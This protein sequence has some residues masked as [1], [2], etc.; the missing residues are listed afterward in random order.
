MRVSDE[1]LEARPIWL[2]WFVMRQDEMT[3][4]DLI[5]TWRIGM[6]GVLSFGVSLA[7]TWPAC[8]V[9]AA[10]LIHGVWLQQFQRH[11]R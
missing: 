7:V 6:A 8:E 9:Q 5:F 3:V 1:S 10:A 2:V 11:I 4:D